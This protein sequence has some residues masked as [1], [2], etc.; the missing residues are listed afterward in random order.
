MTDDL[1]SNTWDIYRHQSLQV[2]HHA[3]S[4][5][6]FFRSSTGSTLVS[7]LLAAM[8]AAEL[9]RWTRF[10]TKGGIGKCSAIRDCIAES[11]EDLMFL[12]V[13]S[14]QLMILSSSVLRMAR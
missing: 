14:F 1:V 6:L 13:S 3:H 2:Q 9:A 7:K 5:S 4:A 8:D 10:A 12:K 11:A